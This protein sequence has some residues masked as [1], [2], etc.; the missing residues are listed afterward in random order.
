MNEEN[1]NEEQVQEQQ[2]EQPQPA[3]E[4]KPEKE[5]PEL[6]FKDKFML[7]VGILLAVII[8]VF[9]VRAMN[10]SEVKPS[11]LLE[12]RDQHLILEEEWLRE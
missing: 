1:V 6:S 10:K 4:Q 5:Y 7:G 8:A 3:Q 12:E 11:Q 2:Q 9:T